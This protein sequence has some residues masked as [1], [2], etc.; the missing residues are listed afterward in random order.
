MTETEREFGRLCAF[1]GLPYDPRVS[2]GVFRS[3]VKKHPAPE[4]DPSIRGVCDEL[5]ERLGRDYQQHCK[6]VST[7]D[8]ETP[9]AWQRSSS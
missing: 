5:F 8:A 7:I 4:V 2:D 3:S 6:K 1:L 9:V